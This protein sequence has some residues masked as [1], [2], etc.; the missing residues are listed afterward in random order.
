M[1]VATEGDTSHHTAALDVEVRWNRICG[2]VVNDAACL[3]SLSAR[4][5]GDCVPGLRVRDHPLL[6][7][8]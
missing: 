7:C 6:R 5:R 1:R 4:E 2:W 8:R 3:V